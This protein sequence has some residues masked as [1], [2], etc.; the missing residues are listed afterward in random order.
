MYIV[1]IFKREESSWYDHWVLLFLNGF[2]PRKL[3]EGGRIAEI[4]PLLFVESSL[5]I[6]EIKHKKER[7]LI[8]STLAGIL[9]ARLETLG[10]WFQTHSI[11]LK[12]RS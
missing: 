3:C 10:T 7:C 11:S 9:V 8:L 12:V 5:F 4:I 1:Q 2:L 6:Y